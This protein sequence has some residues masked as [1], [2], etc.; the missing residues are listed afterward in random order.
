MYPGT[1]FTSELPRADH[2]QVKCRRKNV[3]TV[4]HLVYATYVV[5]GLYTLSKSSAPRP[6]KSGR[7]MV[8]KAGT[9]RGGA[10]K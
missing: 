7:V 10:A 8:R 5:Y 6:V 4:D 3:Y 2:V 1:L 9:C